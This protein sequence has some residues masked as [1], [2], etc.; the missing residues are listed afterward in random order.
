M[1]VKEI[2]SFFEG[3]HRRVAEIAERDAEEAYSLR[4]SQRSL[5][6]CG[7]VLASP[8]VLIS[9]CRITQNGKVFFYA[10]LV[11]DPSGRSNQTNPQT[12]LGAPLASSLRIS[13]CKCGIQLFKRPKPMVSSALFST[14]QLRRGEPWLNLVL[15][16][17]KAAWAP[18]CG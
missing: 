4:L 8:A 10:S 7:E 3:V 13:C 17:D 16:G 12:V 14:D 9:C 18:H 5:R 1:G 11:A 15:R 6:L 2:G